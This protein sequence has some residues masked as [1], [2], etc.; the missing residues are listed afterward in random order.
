MESMLG[1]FDYINEWLNSGIYTFFT[2]A[3]A[4][5]VEYFVLA[6]LKLLTV[7]IPFAWGVA[8]TILQD[9][10]I[11]QLIDAAYAELPSLSRQVMTILRVPECINIALSAYVTK[12]VLRF[13]PGV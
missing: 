2:D 9:L 5:L 8:K 13:I 3:T 11:S 6:Y 4:Y 10:N 7:A 1:F 12:F